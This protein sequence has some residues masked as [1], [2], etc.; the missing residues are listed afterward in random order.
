[1]KQFK[2]LFF[3]G[4]FLL[5]LTGCTTENQDERF[6]LTLTMSEAISDVSFIN[7]DNDRITASTTDNITYVLVE[8]PHNQTINISHSEATFSPDVITVNSNQTLDITVSLD[9]DDTVDPIDDDDDDDGFDQGDNDDV[10]TPDNDNTDDDNADEDNPDDDNTD[11]NETAYVDSYQTFND[12]LESDNVETIVLDADINASIYVNR[13]VQLDLNGFTIGGNLTVQYDDSGILTISEGTITGKL[14]L[15]TPN[16]TV[17]NYATANG[18]VDVYEVSSSS[19][20]ENGFENQIRVYANNSNIYIQ[21][22]VIDFSVLADN[23]HITL[24][25]SV[26][27]FSVED[28]FVDITVINTH[29]IREA[30]IDTP[31]ILLDGIPEILS[32]TASPQFS[33]P[34]INHIEYE[35]SHTFNQGTPL[36]DIIESLP[37]TLTIHVDD[38]EYTVDITSYDYQ[39]A[40]Y[41]FILE[42]AQTFIVTATFDTPDGILNGF[43]LYPEFTIDVLSYRDSNVGLIN[44]PALD[45]INL[46]YGVVD[47]INEIIDAYLP[48]QVD[49][50]T[51]EDTSVQ[52]DV[53]WALD[54][55]EFDDSTEESQTF[56]FT[57]IVSSVPDGYHN[58]DDV[59]AEIQVVILKSPNVLEVPS[60]QIHV[61]SNIP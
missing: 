61:Q 28:S 9:S 6:T 35:N 7:S 21:S 55:G 47:S 43:F 54:E 20:Y 49:V 17:Y 58:L 25:A 38:E 53:S 46:D 10:D 15:Y 16:M 29:H 11:V 56:T 26:G 18:Y 33:L 44:A 19:Y 3:L 41:N 4:F 8:I 27:R 22:S 48:S 52:V 37:S 57:G 36:P 5:I 59:Q 40:D 24:E 51:E 13:L 45:T 60:G 34:V 2:L 39:T 14:E 31:D 30:I 50:L 12:A 23:V 32:G 42:T 1:M